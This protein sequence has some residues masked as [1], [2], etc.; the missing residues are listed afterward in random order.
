VDGRSSLRSIL[1]KKDNGMMGGTDRVEVL[2]VARLEGPG[3][4][5]WSPAR[6][7]A[8]ATSRAGRVEVVAT[9]EERSHL[10][11]GLPWTFSARFESEQEA[12]AKVRS[13]AEWPEAAFA[14]GRTTGDAAPRESLQPIFS[15]LKLKSLLDTTTGATDLSGGHVTIGAGRFLASL[16]EGGGDLTEETT[17][18]IERYFSAAPFT[19]GYWAPYK[20]LLK[21]LE[22]KPEAAG[23]LG[24][25]LARV[26]GQLRQV[27]SSQATDNL[28]P[29]F[30]PPWREIAGPNTVAYMVRRGRRLIRR[31]GRSNPGDYVRCATAFL[32]SAD[33]QGAQTNIGQRWILAEILYGRGV[34]GPHS[35]HGPV[36]LPPLPARFSRRWDRYPRLWNAQLDE[37]RGVWVHAEKNPDIQAWA[38]NVLR[39][40]RQELPRLSKSGLRLALV[41]PADK[42]R[43]HGCEQ[44]A[45]KPARYLDLDSATAQAFLEFSSARQFAAVYPF[46][47]ANAGTRTIQDAVLAYINEHGFAEVCRGATPV[48]ETSRARQLL[49]YSLRFLRGRLD[50]AATFQLARYVGQTTRF[51]PVGQWQDTFNELPLKTLVELRLQLRDLPAGVVRAIDKACRNA[52]AQGVGDDNLAAALTLSP[53]AEL[54]TL[55]WQLLAGASDST[56]TAVWD[57]LVGQCTSDASVRR[58]LESL[59]VKGRLERLIGLPGAPELLSRAVL[60]VTAAEPRV[61]EDLLR[62][63]AATGDSTRTLQTL[64]RVLAEHPEQSWAKRPALLQ[65]IIS[66]D[67]AV[68]QRIWEAT[69]NDEWSRLAQLFLT[70]KNLAAALIGVVDSDDLLRITSSQANLLSG[71][72]R[73]MPRRLLEDRRFAVATSTCPHPTVHQVSLAFLEARDQL[74]HIFLPL[75]ESGLPAAVAASERY[76][77]GLKS[78]DQLT[79][80]IIAI[81]DSGSAQARAVGMRLLQQRADHFDQTALLTALSEHTAPEITAMVAGHALAGR[82]IKREALDRFDGRV[83]RTRRSGRKAKDLVKARLGT[84]SDGNTVSIAAGHGPDSQRIKALMDMAQGSSLRDREWA[85][86]QLARLAI[87]GHHIP[88]LRVSATS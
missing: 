83:L 40:Q 34:T 38:F 21:L 74:Q 44:V 58:L 3:L 70:S 49:R 52:V 77:L 75:V 55:G 22:S 27:T 65:K 6:L 67:P 79:K 10:G 66:T 53:S 9:L 16:V 46:L 19:F 45:L 39:S 13:I 68:T 85:L 69:R 28:R 84:P 80:G 71:A 33:A 4:T 86:Q 87:D 72:L 29:Y 63:L 56:I 43:A 48:L 37:V 18:H 76:V 62:K 24:V 50:E 73:S 12:V 8:V 78:R 41:S 60:A 61:A 7:T 14:D 57:Q 54:R 15:S 32:R 31:L 47:E 11:G 35:G 5:R 64:D 59:R 23:V 17:K 42:V 30:A 1:T 51:K 25:A 88:Q 26:D 82:V 81:C 20:R 36:I 2:C